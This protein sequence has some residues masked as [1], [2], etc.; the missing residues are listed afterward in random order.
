VDAPSTPA[1]AYE[2]LRRA[3]IALVRTLD[4]GVLECVVPATPAWTVHDVLAHVVAIPADLNA[5]N[6]G[7]GDAD[8]WT[9]RQVEERRGRPVGEL[10]EEWSTEA[11]TF[12][13]GL[14]LFGDDIGKHYV[15]DLAQHLIDVMAV[16]GAASSI[17]AEALMFGLDFY[18]DELHAR[19]AGRGIG[20]E[21]WVDEQR[22]ALGA[23]TPAASVH[24]SAFE[25][26]R[27]LGGRRSIAQLR[28]M[29]WAGDPDPVVELLSAYP[30]PDDDLVDVELRP[31]R[32]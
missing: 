25:A 12:E 10:V 29:S 23:A 31:E 20:L 5:S 24:L 27:A 32:S 30:P 28:S 3:F 26:F 4:A 15:G 14:T 6:F 21:L 8:A 18:L 17:D 1:V 22:I 9:A 7:D 11:P 16:V 19:L 2:R 13:A